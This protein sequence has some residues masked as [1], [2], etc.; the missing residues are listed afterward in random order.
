MVPYCKYSVIFHLKKYFVSTGLA[1]GIKLDWV[2]IYI[3]L[4]AFSLLFVFK[5]QIFHNLLL[6][7]PKSPNLK[8]LCQLLVEFILL[9]IRLKTLVEQFDVSSLDTVCF[10]KWRVSRFWS[11]LVCLSCCCGRTQPLW[12]WLW[13]P[14]SCDQCL[15]KDKEEVS[16]LTRGVGGAGCGTSSSSWK[17]TTEM[18]HC[19]WGR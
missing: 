5:E 17:S 9:W 4:Y 12:Q 10:Q 16:T 8:Y 14:S 7:E 6:E 3:D 19:T 18:S 13:T 2:Y 11:C 1:S 15:V